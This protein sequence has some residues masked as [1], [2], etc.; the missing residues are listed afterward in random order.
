MHLLFYNIRFVFLGEMIFYLTWVFFR[1]QQVEGDESNASKLEDA[2]LN[3]G[4][5][6]K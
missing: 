6:V 2:V 1:D 5:C 3:T 4:G